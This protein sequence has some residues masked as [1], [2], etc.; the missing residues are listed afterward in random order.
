M[1]IRGKKIIKNAEYAVGEKLYVFDPKGNEETDSSL[2]GVIFIYVAVVCLVAVFCPVE[3]SLFCFDGTVVTYSR[4]TP[5]SPPSDIL[6]SVFL[7][8]SRFA[9]YCACHI[10]S[11]N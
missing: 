3:V 2:A 11:P 8:Y 6:L 10:F 9:C 5:P 7:L 4:V 1:G